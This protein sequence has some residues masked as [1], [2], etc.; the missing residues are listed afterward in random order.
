MDTC[1]FD[2]WAANYKNLRKE[3]YLGHGKFNPN[4]LVGECLVVRWAQFCIRGALQRTHY[5]R[6][7]GAEQKQH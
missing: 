3:N 6:G 4:S 2:N 5:A 1:T 7:W